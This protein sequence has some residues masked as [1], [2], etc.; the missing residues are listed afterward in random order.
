[1]QALA[2]QVETVAAKTDQ[3][4]QKI[5]THLEYWEQ[6]VDTTM[7]NGRDNIKRHTDS[8][9]HGITNHYRELKN[10][11]QQTNDSYL[12][13]HLSNMDTAIESKLKTAYENIKQA[14]ETQLQIFRN[15]INQSYQNTSQEHMN[16]MADTKPTSIPLIRRSNRFPN[17][18]PETLK[19]VVLPPNPYDYTTE[20]NRSPLQ[21]P[22][23]HQPSNN[24]T[25]DTQDTYASEDEWGRFGPKLIDQDIDDNRPL[26][27]LFPHKLVNHV[28][29]PYL[30]RELTYTWYHTLRS[31]VQQYGILLEPVENMKKDKSICP[32]RY[33]GT[34][35]DPI[36]YKEM[37]DALYQLLALTHTVP[38][39]YT[40]IRNI[41]HRHASNT[42][43]YSA[44]YEILERIHP[45]LNPDAKLNPPMSINCTDI[46]D[47]YNQVDSYFQHCSL[48]GLHYN[49]RRKVNI[50]LDGLDTSYAAAISQIKQQMRSL[51]RDDDSNPPS[52][53]SITSLACTVEQIMN[54]D[55]STPAVVRAMKF[56]RPRTTPREPPKDANKDQPTRRAYVDIQC[57]F[58]LAY[59][60]PYMNCDKM[61]Q[62]LILQQASQKMSE[63]TKA[64]LIHNYNA[65]VQEKRTRRT[66]RVRSTIRQLYADGHSQEAEDL[67]NQCL[68]I[69]PQQEQEDESST[70]SDE[71]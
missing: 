6:F 18:N 16:T 36:R 20:N 50:F 21:D 51:W 12:E 1:M 19:P 11:L 71:E 43:G 47:Y 41:I 62:Y 49:E 31:A 42:D 46:H 33:Y 65:S 27:P 26:P 17:V 22:P 32:R 2:H 38:T 24:T 34:K 7:K 45:S 66:R 52:N 3:R 55:A 54:D 23:M 63:K 28:K 61:A 57:T 39:E 40:D 5:N 64:K 37:A 60:H 29:V 53:L 30:G 69:T 9:L 8:M 59:G 10:K 70:S 56:S 44:L 67:W 4:V 13:Q 48:E 68:E 15:S 25:Q 14:A 58:C 35:I